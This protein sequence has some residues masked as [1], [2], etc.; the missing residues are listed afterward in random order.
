MEKEFNGLDALGIARPIT[1]GDPIRGLLKIAD[2]SATET[3]DLLLG[4]IT[5]LQIDNVVKALELVPLASGVKNTDCYQLTGIEANAD[6]NLQFCFQHPI[7]SRF[8][9]ISLGDL[10]VETKIAII[11]AIER[12]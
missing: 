5:P 7:D 6:G 1:L 10:P 8:D 11:E 3:L 4:T 2:K 9:L 12:L